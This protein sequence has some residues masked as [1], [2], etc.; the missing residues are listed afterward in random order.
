MKTQYREILIASTSLTVIL[1]LLEKYS[2]GFVLMHMRISY[3][4]IVAVISL[5]AYLSKQT[6]TYV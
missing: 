1:F 3:V 5:I 6:E 2:P 4:A